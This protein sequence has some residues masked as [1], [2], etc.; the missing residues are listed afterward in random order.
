MIN[1]TC[2][3]CGKPATCEHHIVPLSLGGRDIPS[4]KAALC[5]ECHGKIHGVEFAVGGMSHSDL[6]KRGIQRKREIIER[7]EV[8][9]ARSGRKSTCMNSGRP[10]LTYETIPEAFMII[11]NSVTYTSVADLARKASMSRN[12]VYKYLNLI[13]QHE[14]K[15][16]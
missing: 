4:N 16:F 14:L 2:V 1:C 12:T 6:I 11:Y 8:F 10:A 7:G 15:N 5:D 13:A 9:V 3:N